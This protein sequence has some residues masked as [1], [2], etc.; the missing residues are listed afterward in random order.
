MRFEAELVVWYRFRLLSSPNE[1][2]LPEV[3]LE[4]LRLYAQLLQLA[5]PILHAELLRTQ[6]FLRA[7]L[8]PTQLLLR[9][10]ELLLDQLLCVL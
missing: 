8:L 10:A 1:L 2:V 3:S 9:N 5:A 7:K 6:L 4:L